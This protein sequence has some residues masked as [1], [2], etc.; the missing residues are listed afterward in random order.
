[1]DLVARPWTPSRKGEAETKGQD[2]CGRALDVDENGMDVLA[3]YG[4]YTI[5]DNPPLKR[6]GYCGWSAVTTHLVPD[7]EKE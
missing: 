3:S 4:L 6:E 7:P 2:S 1:V 5:V